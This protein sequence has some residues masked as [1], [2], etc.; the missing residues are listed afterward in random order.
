MKIIDNKKCV[1]SILLPENPTAREKF[2]AE[3]LCNYIEKISGV[4]LETSG[5]FENK[6]IIGEPDKNANAKESRYPFQG[7]TPRKRRYDCQ[8]RHG[9]F[10]KRR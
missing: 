6:I 1:C 2:A 10:E 4:K 8:R 9:A 7:T 5:D 3:E